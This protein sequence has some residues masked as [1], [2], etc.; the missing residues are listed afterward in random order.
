MKKSKKVHLASLS[1]PTIRI[2]LCCEQ[3]RWEILLPYY[4]AATARHT[5][6]PPDR[7][8][9]Y[10][11]QLIQHLFNDDTNVQQPWQTCMQECITMRTSTLKPPHHLRSSTGDSRS[12]IAV[13]YLQLSTALP[14]VA[15]PHLSIGFRVAPNITPQNLWNSFDW[16]CWSSYI[17]IQ[18]IKSYSY[19]YT[20]IYIYIYIIDER[21]Q[22]NNS[23]LNLLKK[24]EKKKNNSPLNHKNVQKS[25]P[26][27]SELPDDPD[28]AGLRT[29]K[30]RKYHF[31][32]LSLRRLV[33]PTGRPTAHVYIAINSYIH[34]T[35]TRTSNN[36]DGRHVC[37]NVLPATQK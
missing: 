18:Y 11:N 23:P 34:S 29:T 14:R 2:S 37:K 5:D 9:L 16:L 19:R 35:M 30:V 8:H 21:P 3:P 20:Y 28:F 17:Y 15:A 13:P 22:L 7:T 12:S 25:P 36:H 27:C 10:S 32:I 26:S 31:C 1:S 24:V 33:T 6:S 4:L